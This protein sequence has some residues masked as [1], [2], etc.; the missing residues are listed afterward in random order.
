MSLFCKNDREKIKELEA[1]IAEMEMQ[2]RT[3][4]NIMNILS[5]MQ[6]KAKLP[7]LIYEQL[8][9]DAIMEYFEEKINEDSLN[10]FANRF[11]YIALES[12]K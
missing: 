1:R 5:E 2:K 11:A 6:T 12:K 7:K 10:D 8:L 9:I 3:L 4:M